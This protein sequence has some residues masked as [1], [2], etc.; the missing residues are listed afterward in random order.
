MLRA[1]QQLTLA[2]RRIGGTVV[3][4]MAPEARQVRMN[5]DPMM[6]PSARDETVARSPRVSVVV[7]AYNE[8]EL[9][10]G[11]LASLQAQDYA[12]E[13]EVIV[14][15]NASTDAT[16]RLADELGAVVVHEPHPGVCWARQR[17]TLAARGDIIVS[18]DADTTFHPGWLTAI[19]AAFERDPRCVVV[20]GPC[21]WVDAPAWG[22]VYGRVLFSLVG[23]VYWLTGTVVYASATNIAFRRGVWSGYDLN[24]TQ[25]GDEMGLLARLRAHGSVRFTRK[26]VTFTS[27]RRLQRGLLYNLFVTCFYYYLLGYV[28]NKVA[29][30]TVI[31]TAP[32]MD[33]RAAKATPRQRWAVVV[34]SLVVMGAAAALR[35]HTAVLHLHTA[36]LRF[37]PVIPR[38]R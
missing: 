22:R 10:P 28:V 16:A 17:G 25:G 2:V 32:H 5:T 18:T 4:H 7:P 3:A 30:R 8:A 31:G 26:N 38:W 37:H 20:A 24:A 15:D 33:D 13:V 14:A 23:A 35:F 9:L 36:V 34:G 29:R 21:V 1:R 27:S 19:V 6:P 11:C 12:G